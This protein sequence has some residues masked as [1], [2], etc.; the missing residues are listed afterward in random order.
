VVSAGQGVAGSQPAQPGLFA[1]P[2]RLRRT[3]ERDDLFA[4]L[5]DPD[6]H[7]RAGAVSDIGAI[8]SGDAR[9]VPALLNRLEHDP[10]PAVRSAAAG[11]L[12]AYA[13]Q[14]RVH[15]AFRAAAD[16][17]ED[18]T[19]RWEARYALRLADLAETPGVQ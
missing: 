11:A 3:G 16:Q 13:R 14:P 17:D 10:S 5:G 9:T 19:V 4:A 2:G 6:E 18:H 15:A 12:R 7:V 8:A 1:I